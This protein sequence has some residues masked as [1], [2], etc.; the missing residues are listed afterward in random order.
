MRDWT[1]EGVDW[2][3]TLPLRVATHAQRG[4]MLGVGEGSEG[5]ERATVTIRVAASQVIQLVDGIVTNWAD[6]SVRMLGSIV[7]T[8]LRRS[9]ARSSL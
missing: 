6:F 5:V 7:A 2:K 1:G 8:C 3:T 4:E 9:T